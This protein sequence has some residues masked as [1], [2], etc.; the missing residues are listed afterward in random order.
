MQDIKKLNQRDL[1]AGET[2]SKIIKAAIENFSKFGFHGTTIR[3]INLSTDS[4]HGLIY[5]YFPGGKE[6]LFKVVSI[7]ALN[8][9]EAEVKARYIAYESMDLLDMLEDFFNEASQIFMTHYQE[10]KLL[11]FEFW[12]FNQEMNKELHNFVEQT[13]CWLPKVLEKRIQS[14]E[15]QPIDLQAASYLISSIFVNHFVTKLIDVGSGYLDNKENR[16]ALFK[17]IIHSWKGNN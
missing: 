3:D 12:K 1:K 13:Q 6:E 4:A 14:K 2:R 7:E 8:Q 5:H 9:I 11:L 15:I 16:T 10:I 17:N